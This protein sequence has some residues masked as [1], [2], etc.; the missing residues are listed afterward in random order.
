MAL[1]EAAEELIEAWYTNAHEDVLALAYKDSY[2]DK[3]RAEIAGRYAKGYEL[4]K[5]AHYRM[6]DKPFDSRSF[7]FNLELVRESID[8]SDRIIKLIDGSGK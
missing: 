4:T 5:E 8:I 1:D 2:R 6:S 7:G 3:L